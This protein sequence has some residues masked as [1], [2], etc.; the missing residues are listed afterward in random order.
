[1]K[2]ASVNLAQRYQLHNIM[3]V[4]ITVKSIIIMLTSTIDGIILTCAC[5]DHYHNYY[6]HPESIPI[7]KKE[8]GLAMR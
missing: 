5:D 2:W 4:V 1:M 3:E 8:F 6:L 7:R